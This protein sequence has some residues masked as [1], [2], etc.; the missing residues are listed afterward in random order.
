MD[1]LRWH[2]GR[3][4]P[5]HYH[6]SRVRGPVA[7][8]RCRRRIMVSAYRVPGSPAGER[9]ADLSAGGE[10]RS[11]LGPASLPARPRVAGL[12]GRP[13]LHRGLHLPARAPGPAGR[14][15]RGPRLGQAR[16]PLRGSP[17]DARGPVG[18][19][20]RRADR[21]AQQRHDPHGRG[22]AR[23]VRR[24]GAADPAVLGADRLLPDGR[25]HA[26]GA[27]LFSTS[28]GLGVLA[29]PVLAGF[30]IDTFAG[31]R[32]SPSPRPAVTQRRSW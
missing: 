14:A 28:R 17:G 15:G 31:C 26:A 23:G 2:N 8:V 21:R 1:F 20:A 29:G 13:R 25:D 12:R 6:S 10:P 27:S 24:G 16:R 11:E 3:R 22:R 32:F 5:R 4:A 30:A 7:A 9:R 19:R 18:V